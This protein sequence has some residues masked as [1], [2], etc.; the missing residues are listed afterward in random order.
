[1]KQTSL[2]N[3]LAVGLIVVVLVL[4]NI[5][6]SAGRTDAGEDEESGD[7]SSYTGRTCGTRAFYTL[8]EES[9]YPVSRLREPLSFLD[10]QQPGVLFLVEPSSSIPLNKTEFDSL[11]AWV[12][13]GGRAVV[14]DRSIS[15]ELSKTIEVM[16]VEGGFDHDV[17]HSMEPTPLTEGVRQ[18][19]L[20]RYASR[21]RTAKGSPVAQFG[22]ERG[23]VV[24]G[25]R[26]GAGSI[27]FVSDPF[28]VANNGITEGDNLRFAMNL[29]GSSPEALR[30]AGSA[31]FF[32]EYHHGYGALPVGF[33]SYFRGTPVLWIIGQIVCLGLLALYSQGRRFARPVP[34]QQPRRTSSLE[35][36]ASMAN[37]QR[38]ASA[39][40]LAVEN[41]YARLR[42]RLC[43][44]AGL[45][46]TCSNEAIAERI[47]GRG[48]KEATK[49]RA[50]LTR[51]EQI[52][53]GVPVKEP[54]LLSLVLELR[55]L[56]QDLG[57]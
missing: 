9:G 21:I 12:K 5:I 18:L 23:S 29:A 40:D 48:G 49:V 32:D 28:I 20:S 46:S 35:F 26:L 57:I 37:I 6:F 51:A 24:V 56:Q 45:P 11:A 10:R 43:R 8:L 7:R 36:V 41:I 30:S 38:L 34:V 27:V 2:R 4:L 19:R 53:H 52:Q 47:A 39:S 42:S 44:Y 55:Q 15:V 16:T 13:R 33:V 14:F 17:A 25:F 31:I 22:D 1:M 3:G 54:E 50:I